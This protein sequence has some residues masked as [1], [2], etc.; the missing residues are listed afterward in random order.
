MDYQKIYNLLI[1]RA[2]F[3]NWTR[4][5]SGRYV[6]RHHIVPRSLGGTNSKDNLVFLTAREHFIAHWLL[7]KFKNGEDKSKMA[8]A[9]FRMCQSNDFQIRYSKNYEKARIAFSSHN[10]FKNKKIIDLVRER[11]LK[12]NPM[13]NPE[14]SSKVSQKLKGLMVGE[15]NSFYGKKHSSNSIAKVSGDNHYS[16]RENYVPP[17]ISEK[18]KQAISKANTGRKRDD[19]SCRN[20]ENSSIW[21]ITTPD[22]QKFIVKNL[23]EWAKTHEVNPSWL[24]RSRHGYKVIKL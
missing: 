12:N 7:F 5:N 15:K 4:K 9:W 3:R 6:E 8:R 17:R 21:D 16:K 14:I 11:M 18:Q 1:N 13:K 23:N 10:P 19:L 20:K 22:G 24:Y 2:K